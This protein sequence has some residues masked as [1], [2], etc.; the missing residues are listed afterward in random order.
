VLISVI[1]FG[2]YWQRNVRVLESDL[3]WHIRMGQIILKS[4]IPATDPLSYTMPHFPF[5]DHE[6]LTNV[7]LACMYP[8]IGILG[9]GAMFALLAIATLLLQFHG[10]NK[11]FFLIPYMLT[12]SILYTFMGIRTQIVTWFFFSLLLRIVLTDTMWNKF[13]MYIPIII[14]LWTNLHGELRQQ[15]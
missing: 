1:F 3:G 10:K 4:G 9:L 13:R 12:A 8:H 15:V 7:F 2:L 5:V 11:T 14:L 6:W